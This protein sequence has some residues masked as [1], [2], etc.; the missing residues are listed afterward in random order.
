MQLLPCSLA[1]LLAA[2]SASS[3][4]TTV[5][6]PNGTADTPR[7]TTAN[8]LT[9][10]TAPG[11]DATEQGVISGAGAVTKTGDGTLKLTAVNTYTGGT[12]LSAGKLL[13]DADN[14]LAS[15]GALTVNSGY[16]DLGLTNQTVGSLSGTGG[17]LWYG[18]LT[19]NQSTATTFSGRVSN[20]TLVFN[21]TGGGELTLA[22]ASG[23]KAGTQVINYHWE[24]GI[25]QLWRLHVENV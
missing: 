17:F 10:N 3:A 15:T 7:D 21:G 2:A 1:L 13:F 25:N 23:W 9:L 14:R 24:G 6:Y 12:I 22:G 8:P 18:T 4:Q 11:I 16:F 5:D 19:I 20:T